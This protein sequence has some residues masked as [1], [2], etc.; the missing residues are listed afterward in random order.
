[1]KYWAIVID[2]GETTQET[3]WIRIVNEAGMQR[4][5]A[6]DLSYPNY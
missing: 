2:K 4:V 1:M 5:T 6:M 3:Y